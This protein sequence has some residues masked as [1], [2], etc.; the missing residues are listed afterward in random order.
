VFAR[1]QLS[2]ETMTNKLTETVTVERK[3]PG[4]LADLVRFAQW[5]QAKP[6]AF[7]PKYDQQRLIALAR[8]WWETNHGEE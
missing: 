3:V 4:A 7:G 5:L 6:E 2:E 1:A 8:D